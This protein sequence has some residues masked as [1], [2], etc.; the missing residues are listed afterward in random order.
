MT[1]FTSVKK[2]RI[3]TVDTLF[4]VLYFVMYMLTMSDNFI[5]IYNHAV[6]KYNCDYIIT[7]RDNLIVIYN[8]A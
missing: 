5:V 4:I 7:M 8:H 3:T 1:H 6:N 2:R